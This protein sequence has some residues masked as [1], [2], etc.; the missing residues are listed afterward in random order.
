VVGKKAFKVEKQKV[1]DVSEKSKARESESDEDSY[2]NKA[3][4]L[5]RKKADIT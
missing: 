3:S 1:V 5:K 2:S 4:T